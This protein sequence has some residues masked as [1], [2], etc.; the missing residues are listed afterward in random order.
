MSRER[1]ESELRVHHVADMGLQ[2]V[3]AAVHAMVPGMVGDQVDAPCVAACVGRI[4]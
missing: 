1:S 2:E 3:G 4:R